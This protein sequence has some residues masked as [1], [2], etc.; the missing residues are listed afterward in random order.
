MDEM[1]HFIKKGKRKSSNN[2]PL[3]KINLNSADEVSELAQNIINTVREPLIIN[4]TLTIPV[5]DLDWTAA[6]A[7]GG[8][9]RI[10]S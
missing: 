6:R 3:S 5:S 2:P 10:S 4:E 7:S 1:T 9:G 8:L